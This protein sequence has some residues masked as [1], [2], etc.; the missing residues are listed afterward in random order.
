VR[1]AGRRSR[2]RPTSSRP[3]ERRALLREANEAIVAQLLGYY[4]RPWAE[5][6]AEQVVRT[7][8]CECG[9][10][11]CEVS[12]EIPVGAAAAAPVVASGHR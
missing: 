12:V 8:L 11:S 6:Q 5:G 10:P 2:T 7:F 1:P 4:A 9:D 3:A